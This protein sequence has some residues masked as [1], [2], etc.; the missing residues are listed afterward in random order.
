MAKKVIVVD[1]SR[2]ARIQASNV[3]KGAGYDVVE[4][5]DGR[6][7][8]EKI[9]ANADV[10]M[11][12][13]DI[14][15]PRMSGLELLAAVNAGKEQVVPFVML[16]TETQPELVQQAKAHGAKGWLVKPLKPDLLLAAA[17]KIA[18]AAA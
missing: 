16:T 13:C 8:V 11:V 12:L 4:A 9:A 10:A 17:K 7:G 14:N 1:D 5:V 15:M 18:G 2:T 3:L 6:D